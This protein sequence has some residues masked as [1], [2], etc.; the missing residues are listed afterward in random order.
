MK[1]FHAE[2]CIVKYC[3]DLKLFAKLPLVSQFNQL[4]LNQIHRGT[5]GQTG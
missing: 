5:F 3:E 4:E 2:K 1:K